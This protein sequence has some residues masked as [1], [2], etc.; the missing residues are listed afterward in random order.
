MTKILHLTTDTRYGGVYKFI[1]TWSDI[2]NTINENKIYHASIKYENKFSSLN[3]INYRQSN[4]R[5]H[6]GYLLIIDILFNLHPFIKYSLKHDI[7]ILHSTFLF[8][9]G[10]LLKLIFKKFYIVTHDF[11]N[12]LILRYIC[13]NIFKKELI[14]VAPWLKEYF[15]NKKHKKYY[16]SNEKNQ[17][18]KCQIILP[19]SKSLIEDFQLNNIN[20]NTIYNNELN[21]LYIGSLSPVKGLK[22]FLK[23]METLKDISTNLHI[24]GNTDNRYKNDIKN[25]NHSKINLKL[26]GEIINTE[27]KRNIIN[28]ANFAIIPSRSEVFPFVYSE[29]LSTGIIPIC[30]NIIP[31]LRLSNSR[32]HIYYLD[33]INSL[34]SVLKWALSLSKENYNHYLNVLKKDFNLFCSDFNNLDNISKI[35][36]K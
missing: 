32:K 29:Y 6:S 13:N 4:L 24:I 36:I 18:N 34:R 31:F 30:S 20:F 12:P 27:E 28:R 16:K 22:N 23:S 9:V 8:P 33:N 14:C 25:Y 11:N 26:Y 17:N 35:I 5:K 7:I 1:E 2:D 3:L 10:I 21:L 15:I 19:T